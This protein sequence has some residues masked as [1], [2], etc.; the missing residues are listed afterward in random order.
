MNLALKGAHTFLKRINLGMGIG[1]KLVAVITGSV[2]DV[3][4]AMD[5]A[6]TSIDQKRIVHYTVMPSPS[7]EIKKQFR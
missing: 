3:E 2:S 6:V 1:G 4:Q 5:I 7:E